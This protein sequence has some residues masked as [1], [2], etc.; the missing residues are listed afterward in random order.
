MPQSPLHCP[1]APQRVVLVLRAYR[2]SPLWLMP[3]APLQKPK[4]DMHKSRRN[5][6]LWHLRA[7]SSMISSMA[8]KPSPKRITSV[9]PQLL[10][11][12]LTQL[13]SVFNV[14]SCSVR[15][16]IWSSF[17]RKGQNSIKRTHYPVPTLIKSL[18]ER[19]RISLTS[20]LSRQSL[21]HVWKSSRDT[22]LK[23]LL[24][25]RWPI[26]LIMAGQQSSRVYPQK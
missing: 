20:C 10:T 1:S 5:C 3:H 24:W 7:E 8:A 16:T 17:T 22:L 15:G 4:L 6:L 11:S 19:V 2:M 14:N 9:L 18:V 21:P 13:L 26:S 25:R 12:L 23:I